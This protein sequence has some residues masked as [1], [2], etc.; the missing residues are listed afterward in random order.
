MIKKQEKKVNLVKKNN[1]KMSKGGRAKNYEGAKEKS[2][3][4]LL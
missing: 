1:T 3:L 4:L 2:Q